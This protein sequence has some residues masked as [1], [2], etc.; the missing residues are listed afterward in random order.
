MNPVET[1]KIEVASVK[2]IACKRLIGKFASNLNNFK[3][4]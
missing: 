4:H 3:R 1:C 2:D